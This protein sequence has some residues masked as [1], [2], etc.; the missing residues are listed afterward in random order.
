MVTLAA[1]SACFGPPRAQFARWERTLLGLWV[2]VIPTAID[3]AADYTLS[4]RVESEVE[5]VL[6]PHARR[7]PHEHINGDEIGAL[8]RSS[9]RRPAPLA[10]GGH[11]EA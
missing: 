9:H 10:Q 5:R 7:L 2:M 11:R 8:A 4:S 3:P 6:S 1:G